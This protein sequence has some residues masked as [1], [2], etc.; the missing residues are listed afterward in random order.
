VTRDA[1]CDVGAFEFNDFTMI[2]I[3]IDPAVRLDTGVGYA[4]LTGDDAGSVQSDGDDVGAEA[5]RDDR[6]VGCGS[7]AGDRDYRLYAGVG[8]TGVGGESRQACDRAQV[9]ALNRLSITGT[10]GCDRNDHPD[11]GSRKILRTQP[12]P[13]EQRRLTRIVAQ[14]IE[15][16]INLD[17]ADRASA[18]LALRLHRC[19]LLL[20]RPVAAVQCAVARFGSSSSVVI[21]C[22]IARS[23]SRAANSAM[24]TSAFILGD[25]RSIRPTFPEVSPLDTLGER[26]DGPRQSWSAVHRHAT[27]LVRGRRVT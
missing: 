15:P 27:H 9:D 26:L 6:S 14:P 11:V 20:E 16:R 24:P 17:L 23:Y 4:L 10:W 18:N 5:V 12:S 3:T 21:S 8:D 13:R 2:A 7:R 25:S 19:A 1:K 22:S